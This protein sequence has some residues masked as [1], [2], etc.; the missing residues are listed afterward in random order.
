MVVVDGVV[1]YDGIMD[2]SC[3]CGMDCLEVWGGG[4]RSI[5]GGNKVVCDGGVWTF[6]DQG[7]WL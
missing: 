3:E 5:N 4:G 7:S 6:E 2:K 1:V